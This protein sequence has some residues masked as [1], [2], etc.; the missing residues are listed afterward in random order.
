MKKLGS[1]LTT[2][3]VVVIWPPKPGHPASSVRLL[4]A[5]PLMATDNQ[6]AQGMRSI[7]VLNLRDK[8]TVAERC[9]FDKTAT[10]V[11]EDRPGY[12]TPTE[13]DMLVAAAKMVIDS[14]AD[15]PLPLPAL[16]E[17]LNPPEPPTLEEALRALNAV[18][19]AQ[20]QGMQAYSRKQAR[21][22][23][24]RARRTGLLK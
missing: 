10:Y 15:Y 6:A 8:A 11:V 4:I 16:V 2:G 3:D 1:E 21:E 24:D 12:L 7:Q 17:R 5:L 14:G 22:L 19:E 9:I 13:L 20:E 18:A 23:V